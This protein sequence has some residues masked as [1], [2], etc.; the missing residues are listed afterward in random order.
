MN[1][2]E[3]ATIG[4]AEDAFVQLES[5]IY[6]HAIFKLIDAKEQLFRIRE[7]NELTIKPKMK[8]EQSTV[9]IEE[10]IFA[11]TLDSSNSPFLGEARELRRF[12]WLRGTRVKDVD[13]ANPL[14]HD[15]RTQSARDGF[16]LREFGHF[17]QKLSGRGFQS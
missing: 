10:Q 6:V 17:K 11:A 13:A 1:A 3:L 7:P 2:A 15:Q 12:L 9:E 4:E 8:C 14:T 16:Y 5:N